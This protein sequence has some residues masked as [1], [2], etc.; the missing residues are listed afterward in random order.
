MLVE[1]HLIRLPLSVP[2]L[3]RVRGLV[4]AALGTQS[5]ELRAAAELATAELGVNMLK[6]GHPSRGGDSGTISIRMADGELRVSSVNCASAERFRS[7][8]ALIARISS[9]SEIEL[10]YVERL[11]SLLRSPWESSAGLGLIRLS[12]AAFALRCA[13]EEPTLTIVAARKSS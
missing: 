12:H 10:L 4:S 1:D 3:E 9:C 6:F 8:E 5:I 11:S 13:Y 2:W 7:V